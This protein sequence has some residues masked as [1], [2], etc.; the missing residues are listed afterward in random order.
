MSMSI[1]DLPDDVIFMILG[2]LSYDNVAQI[3]G[4]NS[5]FNQ[6]CKQHLNQ[7]F[8]KV[9]E[10]LNNFY[11][12]LESRLPR[13]HSARENHPYS[14]HCHTLKCQSTYMYMLSSTFGKY[15]D[16]NLCCFIPGKIIDEVYNVLN[17]VRV[18]LE[19]PED[20]ERISVFNAQTQDLF[21]MAKGHFEGEILPILKQQWKKHKKEGDNSSSSL[22]LSFRK[23]DGVSNFFNMSRSFLS[24]HFFLDFGRWQT[25]SKVC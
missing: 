14:N 20:Y 9:K 24:T 3:R 13:R 22:T 25:E 6:L 21:S 8:Y 1:S 23:N 16:A 10:V 2:Y 5:F 15:M 19:T 12:N 7:G 17:Y 18:N 4:V 11:N